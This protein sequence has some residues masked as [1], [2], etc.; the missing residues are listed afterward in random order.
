MNFEVR[1]IKY[2]SILTIITDWL[3]DIYETEF[4]LNISRGIR[5]LLLFWFLIGVV[6]NFNVIK[7]Y[8]LT[9]YF[10]I[11][12]IF[13]SLYIQTDPNPMEGLWHLSK[14]LYWFTG[15]MY[16]YYL[17]IKNKIT[18]E[19][20]FSWIK[21]LIIIA[22]IFT[23]Y[24]LYIGKLYEEYN[25]NAYLMV[26]LFPLFVFNI[27]NIGKQKLLLFLLLYSVVITLKRGALLSI[28][29]TLFIAILAYL[30][31]T[32]R[33]SVLNRVYYFLLI[34][35]SASI[36]YM[37]MMSNYAERIE[38]RFSEEQLDFYEDK[39]GSGR[40]G[41]YRRLYEEWSDSKGYTYFFG[42]G[43]Q[44]DSYRI[45]GRRT[46]AHSEFFGWI[47]NYGLMGLLLYILQY[48]FLIFFFIKNYKFFKG[49]KYLYFI[50]FTIVAIVNFVSGF[51]RDTYTFYLFLT[52]VLLNV[53]VN[54]RKLEYAKD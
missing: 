19:Y 34:I 36:I 45:P 54:N 51:Y 11:A 6:R 38:E 49:Y 15:T 16:F 53:I 5:M 40:S 13:F 1:F 18:Y 29:L 42:Y 46:H 10:I 41:M 37:Y 9:Y 25:A 14:I 4:Y 44:A 26:F 22:F 21:I 43:N 47:Y 30:I 33:V 50:F 28:S 35:I 23:N 3:S 12:F 7:S 48:V 2:A 31:N 52:P 39:A 24:Y 20:L 27:E 32:K 8:F 17:L